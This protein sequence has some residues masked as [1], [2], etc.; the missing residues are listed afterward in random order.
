MGTAEWAFRKIFYHPENRLIPTNFYLW[1]SIRK[2]IK[3]KL[4]N[5][6]DSFFFYLEACISILF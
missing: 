4:L 1:V 5:R 6:F 2:P 3:K